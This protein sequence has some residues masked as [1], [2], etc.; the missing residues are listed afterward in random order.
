MAEANEYSDNSD[1]SEE[2]T[3]P[4]NTSFNIAADHVK[5]ITGNLDN[6]QLLELYGLFKQSTEG[7]C[8]LPKPGWFDGRNRRKWEAWKAIEDMSPIKAKQKYIDLV[9]KLDP[10]FSI[11]SPKGPKETWVAVSSLKKTDEPK[12]IINELSILDAARENFGERVTALLKQNP[13]LKNEKDEDGLSALHWAAD[14]DAIDALKAAIS[15]GCPID[16]VDDSGQTALHYAVSCGHVNATKVLL[17]LGA[18]PNIKD[19]EGTTPLELAS[20]DEIIEMLKKSVN[21]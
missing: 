10:E 4:L 9:Q 17:D 2:E 12:L 1:F 16:A 19:S 18:S 6:N 15:G 3:D 11:E 13:A 7:K 5:K 21:S 8:T 14:R 20:D